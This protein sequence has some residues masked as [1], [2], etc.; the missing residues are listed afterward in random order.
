VYGVKHVKAEAFIKLSLRDKIRIQMYLFQ[1]VPVGIKRNK[2]IY[3][4]LDV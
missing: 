3:N 2:F 4:E 1:Y